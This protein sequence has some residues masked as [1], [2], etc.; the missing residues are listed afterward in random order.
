M[1]RPR[2]RLPRPPISDSKRVV[3]ASRQLVRL[4]LHALEIQRGQETL[5]TFLERL[6]V[7]LADLMECPRDQLRLDHEPALENR[8]KEFRAGKHVDYKPRAADTDHLLYRPHAA[9]YA[10]SHHVKTNVR[11]DHGLLSDN[12][13]QRKIKRMARTRAATPTSGPRFKR[14]IA[15]IPSRPFPKGQ[16]GFHKRTPR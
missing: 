1:P 12:A 7:R 16:R 9:E 5:Q 3:V 10:G 4:G 2:G 8:I 11:G 15:K 14:P 6:L 13:L